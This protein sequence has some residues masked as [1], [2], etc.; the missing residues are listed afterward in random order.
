MVEA[1]SVLWTPSPT[2]VERA[3]IVE[4]QRWLAERRGLAFPDFES[5]WQWSTTDIDAFWKACWDFF[6]IEATAPPR[7]VLGRRTMPG[8]EWFP[9]AELNYARH[10]LQ[11][12]RPNATAVLHLNERQG[13]QAISWEELGRRA[14]S[15]WRRSTWARSAGARS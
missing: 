12:E 11:H 5:M 9:G 14:T 13:L 2:R 3:R 15:T 7:A 8:A 6:G 4:F 1:G 10:M